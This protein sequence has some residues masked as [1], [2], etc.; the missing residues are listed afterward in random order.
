MAT[1]P[2]KI[3]LITKVATGETSRQSAIRE[4]F[5]R[6]FHKASRYK[7]SPSSDAKF[8]I[9]L[10]HFTDEANKRKSC[11]GTELIKAFEALKRN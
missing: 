10:R 7:S 1:T 3:V 4:N 2:S 8:D 11:D 9:R 5:H 6:N